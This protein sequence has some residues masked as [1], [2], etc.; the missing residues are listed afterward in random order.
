MVQ[1]F[2]EEAHVKIDK[3]IISKKQGVYKYIT[4]A[5]EM[6]NVTIVIKYNDENITARLRYVPE[7]DYPLMYVEG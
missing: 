2:V 1:P 6:L 7:I 5:G 3:E 4:L